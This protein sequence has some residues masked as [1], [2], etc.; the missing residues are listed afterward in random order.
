MKHL[1]VIISCLFIS[2][3]TYSQDN[4][5]QTIDGAFPKYRVSENYQI[6][7]YATQTPTEYHRLKR[8]GNQLL[9]AGAIT[10]AIGGIMYYHSDRFMRT[11]QTKQ[12]MQISSGI[13]VLTGVGVMVS[14]T[15]PLTRAKKIKNGQ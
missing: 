12:Q 9:V 3:F 13:V 1:I 6:S 11:P 15:I 2:T 7:E 14:A 5:Y 10:S 8:K 4:E